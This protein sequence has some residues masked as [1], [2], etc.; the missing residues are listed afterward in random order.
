MDWIQCDL[1]IYNPIRFAIK[2]LISLISLESSFLH[3]IIPI[4]TEMNTS[5]SIVYQHIKRPK[6]SYIFYI[7]TIQKL[8]GQ[9]TSIYLI[10]FANVTLAEKFT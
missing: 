8:T 7:T 5:I 3:V 10:Y 2:K 1:N 6:K 9:K 4:Y